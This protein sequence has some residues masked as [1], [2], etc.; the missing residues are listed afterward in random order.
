MQYTIANQKMFMSAWG[1]GIE[2]LIFI[3]WLIVYPWAGDIQMQM[4]EHF[5]QSSACWCEK[6]AKMSMADQ[7]ATSRTNKATKASCLKF[8]K[9][10]LCLGPVSS[11]HV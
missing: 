10:F 7:A 8:G 5:L 9:Q 6:M 4:L 3:V 2:S 1:H 11:C